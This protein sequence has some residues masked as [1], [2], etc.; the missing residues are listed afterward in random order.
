MKK[1][2]SFAIL[3]FLIS[4]FCITGCSNKELPSAA[5][6]RDDARTG[7][8]LS[9]VYDKADRV[10]YLGGQGEIV[11]FSSSNESLG[12]DEGNRVGLKV[13]APNENLD[14]E[15]SLLE[16]NGV[17]Y[18]SGEFLETANGQKQRF[19]N[20][21]PLVSKDDEK[22]VFSI[23]WQEGTKTQKYEIKII[24]GTKFMDNE[25]NVE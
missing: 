7:G 15:S 10:I 24:D 6:T 19:F 25:G 5:I 8:S 16:M 13:V 4:I 11:Q 21:Y 3:M 1:I 18:S 14:L 23:T 22:I 20:I 17:S 2:K 9:F 12:L